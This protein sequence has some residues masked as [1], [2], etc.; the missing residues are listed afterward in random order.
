MRHVRLFEEFISS[1]IKESKSKIKRQKEK[2]VEVLRAKEQKELLDVIPNIKKYIVGGKV[3]KNKIKDPADLSK[4]NEIYDK[5]D[6]LIT[7]LL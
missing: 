4:Y 3:I 5:Y 6:K 2:E 7:P 1:E